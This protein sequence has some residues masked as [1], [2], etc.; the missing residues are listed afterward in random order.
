MLLLLL[1]L[2]RRALLLQ[3]VSFEEGTRLGDGR[4]YVP[5]SIIKEV[6]PDCTYLPICLLVSICRSAFLS[7]Y[8]S[9]YPSI[10]LSQFCFA[11]STPSCSAST[12][13]CSPVLL[14]AW[15]TAGLRLCG[16][17][18]CP[19]H[20]LYCAVLCCAGFGVAQHFQQ[21]TFPVT[22]HAHIYMNGSLVHRGHE[23]GDMRG[24]VGTW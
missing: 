21:D 18:N 14:L 24:C 9:I 22:T 12:S 1:M 4:I 19:Q 8:L 6:G 23:V 10:Y 16:C 13:V 11:R 20:V 15:G 2:L 7:V 17:P 5:L 3:H